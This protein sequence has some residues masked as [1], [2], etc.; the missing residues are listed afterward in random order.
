VANGK[1]EVWVP[2]QVPEMCRAAAAQV[3]GVRPDDVTL[4]VTLLGGGFGRRLEVD[5]AA[6]AV[7]VALDCGGA[8]VQLVWPREEDMTH[9]FYRP[10]HVAMLRAAIDDKGAVTSLRIKSA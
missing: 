8:A 2:T 10:M 7:R 5:Y 1:V 6:F 3:G 4:H 9:D